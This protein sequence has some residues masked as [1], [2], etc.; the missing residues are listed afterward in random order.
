[1]QDDPYRSILYFLLGI[2]YERSESS[3]SFL[4]FYLEAWL[5][6]QIAITPTDTA[7]AR[8]THRSKPKKL[9]KLN[10]PE[11]KLALLYSKR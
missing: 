1:M 3:S 8:A 2:A 9:N 6:S 11:G 5:K 4:E 10:K 7:T